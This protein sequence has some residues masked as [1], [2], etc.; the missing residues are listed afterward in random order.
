MNKALEDFNNYKFD[1]VWRPFQLN[2]DMPLD[3]M[4]RQKYLTAKF[5]IETNAASIYQLI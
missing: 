3:G 2:P 5:G 4:D 1:I